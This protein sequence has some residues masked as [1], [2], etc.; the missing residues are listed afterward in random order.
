MQALEDAAL[1]DESV[2]AP[3][4]RQSV[5]QALA[6]RMQVL[7]DTTPPDESMAAPDDRPVSYTH[8]DVYKRQDLDEDDETGN[9]EQP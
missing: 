4:D 2:T 8:L 5:D 1:P 3:D 9:T 7:E 6:G